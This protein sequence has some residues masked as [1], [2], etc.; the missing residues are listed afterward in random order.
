MAVTATSVDFLDAALVAFADRG[1]EQAS[2]RELARQLGVSHNFIPQRFGSKERL[3]YA[4]VDHGFRGVFDDVMAG[5]D[6]SADDV[7]A[8]RA[9]VVRFLEAM[10]IR[11]GLLR[12]I[13][14]EATSP[15]PRLDHLFHTYIEPVGKLGEQILEQLAGAGRVRTTSVSLVYFLMT[16]GAGGPLAL[17]GLAD[18]FGEPIDVSDPDAVHRYAVEAVDVLFHGLTA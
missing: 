16:H 1:Y 6:E 9:A 12:I 11:P 5:V 2:V 8:F 18:R 10:A 14:Q 7:D 15:G 13:A 4:A 17:P 3:W